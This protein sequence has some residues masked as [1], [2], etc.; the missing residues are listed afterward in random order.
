MR[1]SGIVRPPATPQILQPIIDLIQ[2]Q[3]F[4]NK[5]KG[6]LGRMVR[7]LQD[8]GVSSTLRFEPLGENGEQLIASLLNDLK[9]RV[10]GEAVLRV[11]SRY[12]A[13]MSTYT[14]C[15][16]ICYL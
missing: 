12:S 7:S 10:S 3:V 15:S 4:C 6:V 11:G 5:I 2:Y 14:R 1:A 9:T 16:R 8:A 13:F